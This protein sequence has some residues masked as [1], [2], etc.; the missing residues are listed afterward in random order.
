MVTEKLSSTMVP[1]IFQESQEISEAFEKRLNLSPEYRC[2]IK[3]NQIRTQWILLRGLQRR[4]TN[5]Q[6][7][8]HILIKGAQHIQDSHYTKYDPPVKTPASFSAAV[9]VS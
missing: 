8:G 7:K 9:R 4:F 1:V 3:L 5:C 6:G 2:I